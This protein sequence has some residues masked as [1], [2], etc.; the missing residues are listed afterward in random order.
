MPVDSDLI[1]LLD[2]DF[3]ITE[4]GWVDAGVSIAQVILG[5]D[6]DDDEFAEMLV[7][8]FLAGA[9][10]YDIPLPC[11]FRD[12]E[13]SKEQAIDEMR[14]DLHKTAITFI[15]DWRENVVRRFEQAP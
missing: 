10:K 11:D 3:D 5:S 8:A 7:G 4:Y 15:K 13:V 2:Y 12:A 9:N 1:D 14:Q 6:G